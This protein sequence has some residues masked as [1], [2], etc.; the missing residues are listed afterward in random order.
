MDDVKGAYEGAK[1]GAIAHN[2]TIKATTLSAK[3]GKVALQGLA[4]AGN[5]I[6][7]WAI[8]K[9][10]EEVAKAIDNYVNAWENATEVLEEHSS[11]YEDAISEIESVSSKIEELDAQIAEL[12]GL[13]PITNA[14]D[15]EK[16]ELER[17]ILE[18]QVELLEQKRDLEKEETNKAAEDYF[19]SKQYSNI[20]PD[21][22]NSVPITGDPTADFGA[23]LGYYLVNGEIGTPTSS[24]L[25]RVT[26]EEELQRAIDKIKEYQQ[27][28]DKLD[29]KDDAQEIADLKAKIVDVQTDANTLATTMLENSNGLSD[30]T[31][32]EEIVGLVTE[33]NN[34]TD[35]VN[36]YT[37]ALNENTSAK[38]ENANETGISKGN[39]GH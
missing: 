13:D 10:I 12:N 21:I 19:N 33:Y 5:M 24:T 39:V 6:A 17:K 31:R 2:E 27:E 4:M 35:S 22:S 3:A 30:A 25:E 29:S 1:Q 14:D 20:T 37:D 9:V 8:T 16:L 18:A 32:K 28:I 34:L 26:P 7:M 36:G 15:I 38:Q 11:A 23:Q